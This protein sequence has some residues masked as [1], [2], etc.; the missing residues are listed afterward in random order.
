[1]KLWFSRT[2]ERSGRPWRVRLPDGSEFLCASVKSVGLAQTVRLAIEEVTEGHWAIELPDP[3]GSVLLDFVPTKGPLAD[4][5][6]AAAAPAVLG[7]KAA[8]RG[9]R[10]RV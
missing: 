2:G 6:K 3:P 1:M 7:G 5:A 9:R 10:G 4:A 8:R